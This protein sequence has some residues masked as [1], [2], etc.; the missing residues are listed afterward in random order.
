[1]T[2][3]QLPAGH[4]RTARWTWSRQVER[5]VASPSIQS[6]MSVVGFGFSGSGSNAAMAFTMLTDWGAQRGADQPR[7]TPRRPSRPW[8]APRM[9][10]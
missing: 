2:S 9:A 6:N 1:M 5:H 8:P 7:T 4:G 3:I 10:R